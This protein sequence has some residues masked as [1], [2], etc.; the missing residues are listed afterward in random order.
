MRLDQ[1]FTNGEAKTQPSKLCPATLF[2]SIEDLWQRFSFNSQAG[3]RDLS[4]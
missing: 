1:S 2:E 4:T 3:I